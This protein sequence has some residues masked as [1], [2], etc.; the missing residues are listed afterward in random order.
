MDNFPNHADSEECLCSSLNLP[1]NLQKT[2]FTQIL[3]L[4]H[5]YS[6]YALSFPNLSESL[7]GFEQPGCWDINIFVI[8]QICL[9]LFGLYF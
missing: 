9:N 1:F 4:N 3:E 8:D 6:C 7:C 2:R 5:H